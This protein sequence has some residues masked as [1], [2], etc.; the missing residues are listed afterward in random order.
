M[1]RLMS[2]ISVLFLLA[3]IGT[4]AV[5]LYRQTL[6]PC[7]KTLEYSIGRFDTQFGI[8]KE[9]FKSYIAESEKV[10]EKTLDKNVFVYNPNAEFKINL[11]YDE[12]QITT[13]QKQ[14]TEF[15][16]SAVENEF[17]KLDMEF[18][19]FKSEYD[20]KVSLY[21]SAL[22]LYESRKSV[23]DEKVSFWNSKGGA[24]KG[25]Y[26]S[27]EAEIK[28]L[29][30]EAE[31]LNAEISSINAMARQL[32]ILLKE[33][34][35]KALEYNKIA[36]EYNKKYNGGL[37]FNQA[38]YTGNEIN[39]YQ[40]GSKKDLIFAVTHELGHALGMDHTENTTSIMYYISGSNVQSSPVLSEED[41]AELNRVCK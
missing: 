22:N 36:E 32:N 12:R 21:E 6:S 33:R 11:I 37:E 41:L 18:G 19:I 35:S 24:P 2:H 14:K 40:F 39:V 5:F 29:N 38:E 3:L 26:Q 27:L 17:K 25:E 1:K 28:Y 30:S 9:D 31:K 10:W 23:Y 15:G 13:I 7:E 16:L 34:N 4:I 8:S 20:Q